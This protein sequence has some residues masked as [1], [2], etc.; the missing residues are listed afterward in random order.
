MMQIS[1]HHQ[2]KVKSY[3]IMEQTASE[4]GGLV[5]WRCSNRN[6]MA[7]YQTCDHNGFL[8][9][10]G[11]ILAV[12]LDDLQILPNITIVDLFACIYQS[13]EALCLS[14]IFLGVRYPSMIYHLSLCGVPLT[15]CSGGK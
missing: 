2:E 7:I 5:H 10:A 4:R 12:G 8:H 9:W 13:H 11:M 6:W 14:T 15:N 1:V 3:L